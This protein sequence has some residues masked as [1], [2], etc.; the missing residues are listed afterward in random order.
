MTLFIIG[1]L[2]S[3]ERRVA[4]PVCV[5]NAATQGREL[6]TISHAESGFLSESERIRVQRV[7][8]EIRRFIP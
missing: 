3:S 5:T 7:Q 1:A 2:K 4:A 8:L 6:K